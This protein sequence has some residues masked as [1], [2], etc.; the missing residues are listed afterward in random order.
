MIPDMQARGNEFLL[1]T[2][3]A[4]LWW[5]P[6]N[7]VFEVAA[8]VIVLVIV[9]VLFRKAVRRVENQRRAVFLLGLVVMP[10]LYAVSF[11]TVSATLRGS[12]RELIAMALVSWIAFGIDY[13]LGG[14]GGA[15]ALIP[16]AALWF[17]SRDGPE[18]GTKAARPSAPERRIQLADNRRAT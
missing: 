4:S 10:V 13:A 12:T 11:V 9:V 1:P 6:R 15:Y 18:W 17:L 16:I 2:R 8:V 14:W 5:W 3:G 7:T